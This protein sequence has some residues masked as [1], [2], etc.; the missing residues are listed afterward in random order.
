MGDTVPSVWSFD[1]TGESRPG[2][3]DGLTICEAIAAAVAWTP[4]TTS[5]AVESFVAGPVSEPV[6]RVEDAGGGDLEVELSTSPLGAQSML[7][8]SSLLDGLRAL[9]AADDGWLLEGP[10]RNAIEYRLG[11][12]FVHSP[13]ASDLMDGIWYWQTFAHWAVSQT[14]STVASLDANGLDEVVFDI[15]PR[16][17]SADVDY[18]RPFIECL[19][20][21]YRW[22]E[23]EYSLPQAP[24]C[25]ARLN[26]PE[27]VERLEALMGDSANFDPAKA[28]VMQARA[29]GIDPS[30]PEGAMQMHAKFNPRFA[31]MQS[32]FAG[33]DPSYDTRNTAPPLGPVA[34]RKRNAKRK[35]ARKARKKNR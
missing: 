22:L 31:N 30:T 14:G 16:K 26:A 11:R 33:F 28:M 24:A 23:N 21:F 15:V 13:E 34:K 10:E 5:E 12:R 3:V 4:E 35:A 2:N 17:V 32:S 8:A 27:S 1:D 25:L 7:P 20:A 6:I 19:R 18:A 29:A 9:E